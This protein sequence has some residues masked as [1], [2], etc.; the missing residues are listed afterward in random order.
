MQ[1]EQSQ[2]EREEELNEEDLEFKP[3]VKYAAIGLAL[4]A[5]LGV[6]YATYR[7]GF[8]QGYNEGVTSEVVSEAVNNAA[9]ENLTH[10]MQAATADD[11]TLLAAV[12]NRA[13][14][15]AWIKNEQVRR[16]AEWS[17][18]LAL[19][20]RRKGAEVEELLNSLFQTA[21][22]NE[23]WIHRAVIVARAMADEGS[24]QLALRHYR[25]AAA[26]YAKLGK[27]R[28][29]LNMYSE[30]AGLIATPTQNPQ[31]QLAKLQEL[32]A[33]VSAM[34]EPAKQ[35]QADLLAHIGRI[36][37]AHGRHE[38][39]LRCFEQALS[40]AD[41]SKAP[42]LA[43]A[44]VSMGSA[45]LEK[46]DTERAAQLLRDGVSRLGE[47]PGD[48]AYL[49][50]A[51]RDLARIEAGQGNA[52]SALALLYRA[53]GAAMGRL[54]ENS[55][56]WLCLYDQRGWIHY[57][58]GS[59]DAA[60]SDFSRALAQSSVPEELRAQP[61]EGAGSCCLT[62]ERAGE[63]VKYLLECVALRERHFAGDKAAQGRVFLKLA[64]GYDI[65][66]NSREAAKYYGL[67]VANLP[68]QSGENSDFFQASLARAYACSQIADWNAAI[69]AWDAMR[70]LVEKGSALAREIE[71]QFALCLR[72]GATLADDADV[73]D[74]EPAAA[75]DA[76]TDVP[77][78]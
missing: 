15:L 68:Q 21:P 4:V 32:L 9:V 3:I 50:A 69:Q 40:G 37:R 49:A 75:A 59:L 11:A 20:N 76:P 22:A 10:F 43:A 56:Y 25:Y 78:Q 27:T 44:A 2:P 46:G 33:D 64:R 14:G 67:A 1:P 77:V 45:L 62:P 60:F 42:A 53:E 65:Q 61:L 48:A 24:A 58:K 16:E 7:L 8:S 74:D 66:G 72:H 17:L 30:I 35:L 31:E 52:E 73:D 63:A 5:L 34:G 41:L 12:R 57:T 38:E 39:A 70:P 54:P 6:E 71:E 23:I 47:H 29:Q 26:A 19:I 55:A 36:H 13:T 51:L 18:A 28:E